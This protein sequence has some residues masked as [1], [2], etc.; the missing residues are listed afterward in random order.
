MLFISISSSTGLPLPSK[1]ISAFGFSCAQG[2]PPFNSRQLPFAAPRVQEW[3]P[4]CIVETNKS[5]TG[6]QRNFKYKKRSS[7]LRASWSANRW[8]IKFLLESSCNIS[9]PTSTRS[10]RHLLGRT[11]RLLR[12]GL[13]QGWPILKTQLGVWCFVKYVDPSTQQSFEQKISSTCCTWKYSVYIIARTCKGF[14]V[15]LIGLIGL[16]GSIHKNILRRSTCVSYP[17]GALRFEGT[18]AWEWRLL[19]AQTSHQRK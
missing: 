13:A 7:R 17:T 19:V 4:D 5:L 9:I 12:H 11:L 1:V 3:I 10:L 2:N 8:Q 18:P 16:L 14:I 6:Q 15:F